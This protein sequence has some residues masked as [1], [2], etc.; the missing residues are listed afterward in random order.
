MKNYNMVLTE[1]QQKD[2]HYLS[3]KIDRYEHLA[4]EEILSSGQR[5]VI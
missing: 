2:Q 4:G 1:T 3:G 5:R